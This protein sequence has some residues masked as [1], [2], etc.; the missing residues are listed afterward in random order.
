MRDFVNCLSATR[1]VTFLAALRLMVPVAALMLTGCSRS[2]EVI[3]DSPPEAIQTVLDGLE[4]NRPQVVWNALPPGYQTDL[5]ELLSLFC[6]NMDPDLYDKTFRILGKAVQVL[7]KKEDYIFNSPMALNTPLIESNIGNHWKEVVGIMKSIVTSDISTIA[8]LSQIEPGDFLA[9]TG[10]KVM[11][12]L[13][14]LSRRSQRSGSRDPW[15]SLNQ[16]LEDA[17]I[18]FITSTNNQGTLKFTAADDSIEEVAL[19]EV[20]GRWIPSEMARSW[21]ASMAQAKAGMER[22]N[23]PEIQKVTP[24]LSMVLATV[25]RSVDSLLKARSQKEFDKIL[26]GLSSVREMIEPMGEAFAPE[27]PRG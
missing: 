15:E 26:N 2:P 12:D 27:A 24:I 5:R 17:R 6:A 16:A 13:Q 1:R 4:D 9:S 21:E 3:P 23:G 11:E 25:E 7:D 20:E 22:L 18:E 14:D 19:T 8:T 10:H